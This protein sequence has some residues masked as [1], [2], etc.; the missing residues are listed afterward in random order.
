MCSYDPNSEPMDYEEV[1]ASQKGSN[2]YDNVRKQH[3]DNET[4]IDDVYYPRGSG[5][6]SGVQYRS[7]LSSNTTFNSRASTLSPS[8]TYRSQKAKSIVKTY[9]NATSQ[10]ERI[11]NSIVNYCKEQ[12]HKFVDDSFPPCDKSLFIG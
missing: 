11:W 1:D 9:A 5:G 2:Q 10:A 8:L 4:D 6:S 12:G 3:N 7:P